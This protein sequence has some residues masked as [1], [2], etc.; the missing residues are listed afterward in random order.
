VIETSVSKV[1]IIP[2]TPGFNPGRSAAQSQSFSRPPSCMPTG[3]APWRVVRGR[4][5]KKNK[6]RK[7]GPVVPFEVLPSPFYQ[8]PGDDTLHLAGV[9][10]KTLCSPETSQVLHPRAFVPEHL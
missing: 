9:G 10:S 5:G 1:Q 7:E 4:R 8:R 2:L 6:K 3:S